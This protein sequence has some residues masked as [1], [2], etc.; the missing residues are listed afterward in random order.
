[1]EYTAIILIDLGHLQQ[2][3][4][5]SFLFVG[6]HEFLF[7]HPLI[8]VSFIGLHFKFVEFLLQRLR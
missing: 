5:A 1:M 2:V 4:P 8:V 6:L 3:E 7:L